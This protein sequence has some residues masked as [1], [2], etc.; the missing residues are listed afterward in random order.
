MVDSNKCS[1]LARMDS[2][3]SEQIV[4]MGKLCGTPVTWQ[5]FKEK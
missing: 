4:V 3:D 1:F 5:L 2:K